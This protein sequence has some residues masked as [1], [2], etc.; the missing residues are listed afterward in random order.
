MQDRKR[1]HIEVTNTL[2]TERQTLKL[3]LL[4]SII[5]VII[6]VL[7]EYQGKYLLSSQIQEMIHID[8]IINISLGLSASAFIS[9]ASLV[10][11]YMHRKNNNISDIETRL[12]KIYYHYSEILSLINDP[13]ISEN[14]CY[15]ENLLE[16]VIDLEKEIDEE[17]SMYENSE[18]ISKDF[19]RINDTLK[20]NIIFN[21]SLIRIF[22]SFEFSYNNKTFEEQSDIS[23]KATLTLKK[24]NA[25]KLTG[26]ECYHH[27]S[28]TIN[29]NY[30]I[31]ELSKIFEV[32]LDP[33][34]AEIEP[35]IFSLDKQM[36]KIEENDDSKEFLILEFK[37]GLKKIVM[38]YILKTKP[39]NFNNRITNVFNKTFEKKFNSQLFLDGLFKIYSVLINNGEDEAEQ[40]LTQLEKEI[41]NYRAESK[42]E[43]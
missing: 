39:N 8:Y 37:H 35:I 14:F 24:A 11:S 16:E 20:N 27:L 2:K 3:L 6:S 9:F 34:D 18:F 30:S 38:N 33:L 5:I 4:T 36:K 21:L 1:L 41:D 10:F 28:E 25:I 15:E 31:K 32:I 22:V 23:P 7:L 42:S 29:G 13:S 19:E 43:S 12:K 40:L 17:I 26:I